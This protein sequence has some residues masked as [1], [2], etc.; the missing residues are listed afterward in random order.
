MFIHLNTF[1][2]LSVLFPPFC[3]YSIYHMNNISIL[4]SFH[5]WISTNNMRSTVMVK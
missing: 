4:C 1:D 5:Q 2:L 3:P